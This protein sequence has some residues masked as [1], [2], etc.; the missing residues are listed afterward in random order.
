MTSQVFSANDGQRDLQR[1]I[2]ELAERL[3]PPLQPLARLMYNY[4]WAWLPGAGLLFRDIDFAHWQ[5][6]GCNPRHVIEA[7]SPRRLQQLSRDEPFVAEN[8]RVT[9]YRLGRQSV[10]RQ[11]AALL[12]WR[13]PKGA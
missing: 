9:D 3:P 7:V 8:P 1:A 10:G 6:S 11:I 4:R 13:P 12:Q 2:N 5:R